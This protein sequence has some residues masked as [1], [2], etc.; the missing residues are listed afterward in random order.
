MPVARIPRYL[1]AHPEPDVVAVLGA[2]TRRL[3][4]MCEHYALPYAGAGFCKLN[5][6]LG[7]DA[8]RAAGPPQRGRR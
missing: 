2:N 6:V 5:F 8:R 1:A 7:A 3:C 4:W